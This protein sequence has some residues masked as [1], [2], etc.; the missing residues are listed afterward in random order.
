MRSTALAATTNS[1]RRRCPRISAP[2]RGRRR[3]VTFAGQLD[4]GR[5]PWVASRL[6]LRQHASADGQPRSG[7]ELGQALLAIDVPVGRGLDDEEVRF[8]DLY[9]PT[10][11]ARGVV[12]AFACMYRA[13]CHAR[14]ELFYPVI[15][16]VVANFVAAR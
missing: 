12:A 5:L 13:P 11:D 2:S 9:S 10:K 7:S 15:K 6:L 4:E 3:G 14:I 8:D 1:Q 16:A